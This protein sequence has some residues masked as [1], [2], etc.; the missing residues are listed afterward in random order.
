M[1]TKHADRRRGDRHHRPEGARR[2]RE[3]EFEAWQH[4][5]NREAV[6]VPGLHRRRGQPADRG[7]A[8]L[9]GGLPLRLD[10]P[11]A[12]LDQQRHPAGAARPTAQP[13]FDG[14]GTQQVLS[15]GAQADGPA[16]HRRRHPPRRPGERRRLPGVAGAASAG[17]ER[18]STAS[19]APSCSAPSRACRRSGPRCTGSTPPPTSTRG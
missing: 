15:G 17:G 13:F 5:M 8:R 14:P 12:G 16:G 18:G 3:R 1:D 2:A 9:G 6:E 4:D 11:R 19:A 7:A 10:R